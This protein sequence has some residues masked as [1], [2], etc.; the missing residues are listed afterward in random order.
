MRGGAHHAVARALRGLAFGL[1][2]TLAACSSERAAPPRNLSILDQGAIAPVRVIGGRTLDYVGQVV[3]G[4]GLPDGGFLLADATQQSLLEFEASGALRRSRELHDLIQSV[5]GYPGP[6]IRLDDG[7]F[8]MMSH[9]ILVHFST[10]LDTLG[11]LPGE[12]RPGSRLSLRPGGLSRGRGNTFWATDVANSRVVHLG[13]DGT[14][15]SSFGRYCVDDCGFQYPTGIVEAPDGSIIVADAALR[16]VRRFSPEGAYLGEIG[17]SADFRAPQWI[18]VSATGRVVILDQLAR[19]LLFFPTDGA[20]APIR[21]AALELDEYRPYERPV[22]FFAASAGDVWIPGPVGLLRVADSGAMVGSFGRERVSDPAYFEG[23]HDIERD[24][25]GHLFVAGSDGRIL[26]FDARGVHLREMPRDEPAGENTDH[27]V[28]DMA[29]ERNGTL[30]VLRYDLDNRLL[31]WHPDRIAPDSVDLVAISERGLTAGEV[32]VHPD[33][34]LLVLASAGHLPTGQ[35]LFRI[36][37]TGVLRWDW[38][39]PEVRQLPY[40]ELTAFEVAPDGRI[41][42]HGSF[43][44]RP[45]Y[46]FIA[47]DESGQILEIWWLG[48]TGIGT[49]AQPHGLQFDA[50]GHLLILSGESSVLFR[51]RPDGRLLNRWRLLGDSGRALGYPLDAALT[52]DGRIAVSHIGGN[53]VVEYDIGVE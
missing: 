13:A 44:S 35:R 46:P 3:G 51:Y 21:S 45:P 4:V 22:P 31:R 25:R 9:S 11:T 20:G 23:A 8:W 2:L 34:D 39:V 18:E 10:E 37:P 1:P 30:N 29:V 14:V 36:A 33:G 43:F 38:K 19:Q 40:L 24:D 49:I 6:I 48:I 17:T 12:F 52:H 28:V 32:S 41:W 42:A 7:T 15:L 16:R 26:E 47:F 5:S 27:R 50:Q 53:S